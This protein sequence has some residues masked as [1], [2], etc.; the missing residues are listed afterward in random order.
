[1]RSLALIILLIMSGLIQANEPEEVLEQYFLV[2]TKRDFSNLSELMAEKSM[3]DLKALA[4]K[5]ISSQASQG[6]FGLQKRFFGQRLA[7]EAIEKTPAKHYLDVLAGEILHAAD[8]THFSVDGESILGRVEEGDDT[9]HLIAR[10][11]MHQDEN[12]NSDVMLYTL[13]LEHGQWKLTF[14]P[15]FKQILGVLEASYKQL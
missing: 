4:D 8:A 2:L 9:V 5:A 1:M 13:V 6:R 15:T 14:P 3:V 7:P 10:L 11:Q 12:S